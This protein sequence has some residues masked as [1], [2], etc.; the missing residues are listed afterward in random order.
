MLHPGFRVILHPFVPKKDRTAPGCPKRLTPP[1]TDG[2]SR[3]LQRRPKAQGLSSESI[4]R[5]KPM[6]F[7]IWKIAGDSK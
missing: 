2:T 3:L 6:G 4:S 1:K 5:P 7:H